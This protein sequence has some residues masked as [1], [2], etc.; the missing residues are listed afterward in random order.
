MLIEFGNFL[1]RVW[2]HKICASLPASSAEEDHQVAIDRT[3]TLMQLETPSA[4]FESDA[5]TPFCFKLSKEL[6]VSAEELAGRFVKEMHAHFGDYCEL[7]I[8]GGGYLN[9]KFRTRFF[10]HFVAH[11]AR[12][13]NDDFLSGIPLFGAAELPPDRIPFAR[14]TP[15]AVSYESIISRLEIGAELIVDDSLSSEELVQNLLLAA[16]DKDVEPQIAI[17][18]LGSRQCLSWYKDQFAHDLRRMQ[19]IIDRTAPISSASTEQL[20][21]S[22]PLLRPILE[23]AFRFRHPFLLSLATGHPELA[24][25]QC[26]NLIDRFYQVFNHP[27]VRDLSSLRL[28]DQQLK[29]LREF[30]SRYSELLTASLRLATEAINR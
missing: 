9:C 22:N 3:L 19:V 6:G 4:T 23:G 1:K 2:R 27:S 26:R 20:P 8:G 29:Q 12:S 28:T 7:T 11:F 24:V 17:R 30:I 5:A 21:L 18:Q 16:G 14:F 13:S 15:P 10:D 25:V